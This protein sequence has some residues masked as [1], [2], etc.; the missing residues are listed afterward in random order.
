MK[1]ISI[2]TDF[3]GTITKKDIGDE[4]FRRF[5]EFE[6]HHTKFVNGYITIYD[7]W[8][9]VCSKLDKNIGFEDIRSFALKAETDSYFPRFAEFCKDNGLKLSI[10]SDGF[11]AYI[12][13]ILNKLELGGLSVFC[14]ELYRDAESA[15][16]PHFPLAG[17]SCTCPC[18][19]C[20]RNAVLTSIADDDIV[21]YIGDGLS[22]F[23]A[24]EHAD[25][26]FAKKK[27]AAHCNQNRIPHYPFTTFFDVLRI[28][29]KIL[30]EKTRLKGR[31]QARLLRKKAYETE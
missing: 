4:L 7:Y 29:K 2:F 5:G 3:D 11:D 15:Y 19:S 1:N 16:V 14:N 26:I 17:E 25:I 9:I 28:L 21:V 6:P 23:C 31:H 30:S 22:D 18:A 12:Y 27:L 8:H 10:V 13:P 20:K 24:A